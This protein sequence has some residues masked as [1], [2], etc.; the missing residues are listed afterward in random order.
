MIFRITVLCFKRWALKI[1]LGKEWH[2][3]QVRRRHAAGWVHWC[4]HLVA[5]GQ[6]GCRKPLC[7]AVRGSILCSFR[8]KTLCCFCLVS[9]FFWLHKNVCVYLENNYNPSTYKSLLFLWHQ[10]SIVGVCVHLWFLHVFLAV[11]YCCCNG[12]FSFGKNCLLEVCLLFCHM[13]FWSES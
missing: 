1:H 3:F 4:L 2:F 10:L 7:L 8:I 11:S 5:W 13:T 9:Q 12:L 6:R